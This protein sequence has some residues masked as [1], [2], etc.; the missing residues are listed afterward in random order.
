VHPKTF[1]DDIDHAIGSALIPR[2]FFI[3]RETLRMTKTYTPTELANTRR[4]G[5][6]TMVYRLLNA[7]KLKARK[8]GRKTLIGE[9]EVERCESELPAYRPRSS[10]DNDGPQAA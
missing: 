10:N 9:T 6:R 3:V 2:T 5:G 7:G 4:L 8:L 1:F